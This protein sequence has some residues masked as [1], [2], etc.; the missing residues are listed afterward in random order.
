[1]CWVLSIVYIK[2]LSTSSNKRIHRY[3][4][5]L[6]L[7]FSARNIT[8]Y[9]CYCCD[10]YLFYILTLW[11]W[12]V[13][14]YLNIDHVDFFQKR[15]IY[16]RNPRILPDYFN[17]FLLGGEIGIKIMYEKNNGVTMWGKW[18]YYVVI[19]IRCTKFLEII[20]WDMFIKSINN[21]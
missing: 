9:V 1:M 8:K 11:L 18:L 3:R 19:R 4:P 6:L 7:L 13:L 17:S 16:Q 2:Y 15:L 20:R 5:A 12:T 21:W 10:W 14:F